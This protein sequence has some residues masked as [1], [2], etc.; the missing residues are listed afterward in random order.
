MQNKDVMSGVFTAVTMTNAVLLD[1]TTYGS[2]IIGVKASVLQ[3]VVSVI[4]VPSSLII[5][6]LIMEE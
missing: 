1:A 5:F 3:L 2:S 6:T 4:I